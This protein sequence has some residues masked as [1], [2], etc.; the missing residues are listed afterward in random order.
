MKQELTPRPPLLKKREGEKR[1]G[2]TANSM[3]Q[4]AYPIAPFS[5]GEKGDGG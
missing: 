2:I 5:S 1:D 3:I 4:F